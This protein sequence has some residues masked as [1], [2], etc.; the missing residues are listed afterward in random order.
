MFRKTSLVVLGMFIVGG[1]L[2]HAFPIP[3]SVLIQRLQANRKLYS[4]WERKPGLRELA[5][6]SNNDVSSNPVILSTP[7]IATEKS[8]AKKD[9]KNQPQIQAT[10][11]FCDVVVVGTVTRNISSLTQNEGFIFTDSEVLIESVVG[12]SKLENGRADIG[13]GSE[14]TVTSPG[15][16]VVA[17]GHKLSAFLPGTLPLNVNGRY[18]LFLKYIPESQSYKRVD[19]GGYDIS[20]PTALPLESRIPN[21]LSSLMTDRTALLEAISSSTSKVQLHSREMR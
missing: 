17:D 12:T 14:I 3:D 9:P 15:G 11:T 4:K 1:T 13:P 5:K 2:A 6:Q 20:N 19:I 16:R 8:L 10:A 18:I 21:P 7:A